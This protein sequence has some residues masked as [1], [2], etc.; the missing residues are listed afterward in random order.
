MKLDRETLDQLAL[1]AALAQAEKSLREGGIPI[2][3]ALMDATGTIVALGQSISIA[4]AVAERSG[5][6]IST[7]REFVGQGLAPPD[8]GEHAQPLRDV[9]R[10]SD[11]TSNSPCID[12]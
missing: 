4:K 1:N 2:G 9:Q 5:Q 11:S 7:D 12:W 3:A 8:A 6:P 10:H